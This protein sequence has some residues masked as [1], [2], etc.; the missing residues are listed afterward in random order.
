ML[1]NKILLFSGLVFLSTLFFVGCSNTNNTIKENSVQISSEE[2]EEKFEI[3]TEVVE[4]IDIEDSLV[5]NI[6]STE[7]NT[8]KILKKELFFDDNLQSYLCEDFGCLRLGYKIKE[9]IG[10]DLLRDAKIL[11][12]EDIENLLGIPK[13]YYHDFCFIDGNYYNDEDF[14]II[15]RYNSEDDSNFKMVDT[16]I[17]SLYVYRDKLIESTKGDAKLLDRYLNTVVAKGNEYIIM[18]SLGKPIDVEE[19]NL[20]FYYENISSDIIE[21]FMETLSNEVYSKDKADKLGVSSEKFIGGIDDYL[22][23]KQ[24][25]INDS[26]ED[27]KEDLKYKEYLEELEK[28]ELEEAK[29][30]QELENSENQEEMDNSEN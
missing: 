7:T 21:L 19:N 20:H 15:I 16:I 5:I 22:E 1:K 24:N 13:E 25:Y 28:Q 4:D 2:T 18:Y 23:D 30:Q 6:D 17:N 29:K 10:Y 12:S 14:L 8:K 11:N 9:Y 27:L 3:Q 26:H